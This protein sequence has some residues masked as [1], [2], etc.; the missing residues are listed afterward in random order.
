MS[1]RIGLGIAQFPSDPAALWRW[2]DRVERSA[3][4]SIWQSDRL[5]S[6]QPSLEAMSLM[7]ALAARTERL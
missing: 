5:V 6:P 3:V 7:A 2:V 4:D 1:V